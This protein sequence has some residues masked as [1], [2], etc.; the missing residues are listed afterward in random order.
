MENVRNRLKTIF[1]L[2]KDQNLIEQRS[3]QN[4]NGTHISYT[5]YESYT[6]N[7]NEVDKPNY[8]RFAVLKLSNLLT[9]ELFYENLQLVFGEKNIQCH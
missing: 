3:N 6:I 5:I 9:Y 4:I 7:Q 1:M 8:L 2:K